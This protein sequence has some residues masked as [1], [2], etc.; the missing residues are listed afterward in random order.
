MQNVSEDY[1][2]ESYVTGDVQRALGRPPRDFAD[3]AART[4]A[5]GVWRPSAGVDGRSRSSG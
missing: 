3:Y 2:L 5:T 4:A 1:L